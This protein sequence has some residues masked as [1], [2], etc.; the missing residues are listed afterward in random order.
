MAK[1][2]HEYNEESDEDS[3]LESDEFD[4]DEVLEDKEEVKEDEEW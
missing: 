2:G 4:E 1:K 3:G